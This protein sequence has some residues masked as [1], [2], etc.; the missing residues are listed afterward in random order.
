MCVQVNGIDP[1]HFCDG[2]ESIHSLELL[3]MRQNRKRLQWDNLNK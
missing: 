3:L 2:D 1:I